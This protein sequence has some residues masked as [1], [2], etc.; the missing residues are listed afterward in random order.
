MLNEEEKKSLKNRIDSS[1]ISYR[2]KRKKQRLGFYI[3]IAATV[4]A[5]IS[6]TYTKNYEHTS[7]IKN[8]VTNTPVD[9]DTEGD[10]KLVLDDNSEIKIKE[11]ASSI[12]Y[13]SSGDKVNINNSQKV[14]QSS[15]NTFNTIV[16]PYGKRT[17][18]TLSEGTKVW[19]N[20]GSKLTYPVAFN[21]DKREVY[22][23]GEAIFDVSHNKEK[24]FYVVTDNYDI[25]VLG[26]VFNVS[27]YADDSYAT[28]ALQKGSVEIKYNGNS[29]FGK[30][31]LKITP[32]T[33]AIYNNKTKNINSS[34]VDVSKYMSWR[35]GK[36]IFKKEKMEVILKK[37]S[38]YYNVT[39]NIQNEAL[40]NQT[41]SGHLDLKDTIGMV[42]E[43]LKQTTDLKYKVE[44]KEFIIN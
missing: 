26:T 14:K 12:T 40:K 18:I 24:P 11:K 9:I 41:F 4:I 28:T 31:S 1:I 42:M 20:S 32:G 21:G 43:V 3:G 5:F 25:K 36:F 6:I 19:L 38:R 39:I 17:K 27:S 23:I 29:I 33:L 2:N 8:Y 10:V 7:E 35:D 13:S 15:G 44:N 16:V 37:L 30:S 22:L 34:K